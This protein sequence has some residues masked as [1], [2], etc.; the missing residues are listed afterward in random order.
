VLDTIEKTASYLTYKQTPLLLRNTG[1]GF[2]NVSASAGAPFN[3]PLAARGAAVGD[4]DNDGDT[5]IVLA[6][7]DGPALILRNNNSTKNHW[8][9][10][11]LT[12][13]KANR[14]GFGARLV[15]TDTTGRKQTFDVTNAGSYLASND[16]RVLVGLG[17][18]TG[19]N[20]IEVR[21]PGGRKQLITKPELDRYL[22]IKEQ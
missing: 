15:V 20:S 9:G 19:V 13:T 6:Q 2:V 7:T 1:R 22:T 21:W 5:D 3:V 8:L 18:A 14:Q 16:P 4:I 11:V 10:V 12:G 17:T